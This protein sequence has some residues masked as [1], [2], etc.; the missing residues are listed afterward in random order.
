MSENHEYDLV[1]IGAGSGGVRLARM[2]AGYGARVAVIESRYLGGTCVN[3]GCVP[4]KLF[5]YG[6]HLPEEIED[7]AGYGW[8]VQEGAVSFDWSTLVRNK[9]TEISRLNGIY[10][11]LL[12]GAGVDIIEGTATIDDPH[13]VSVG[14]RRLRARHIAVATGS[15]P[16][17][18]EIPGA[19]FVKTSN[20]MFFLDRL[21]KHAI[22]WGGGYIAVEF[23]GILNGLGVKTTLV[24]RGE[25]F[26]RGFDQD[27]RTFVAEELGKK[28]IELCFGRNINSVA[29]SDEGFRVTLDNGDTLDTGL[30]L[31]ATGRKPLLDGLGLDSLGVELNED[32]SLKVD[33]QFRTSV[34]SIVALGDVIGTPQLTPVAI[35]QGMVL[36]RNLFDGGQDR[37]DYEAIPTAV[38]CQPNIGTVGLTEDEARERYGVLRIYRTSFRPMKYTLSGRDERTLMKLVVDDASDRVVGAHMVGPDAGEIIQGIAV[39]IKAG[40]TKAVFDSTIGI[41]PTSAEEFVTMRQP[42]DA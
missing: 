12:Q 9:N 38:F 34:P 29:E 15:W 11:K 2:S 22:V 26:L 40:A 37:M 1:V 7:A 36:S 19:Q 42:V 27:V 16:C 41:H 28:G 6:S 18:P 33:E 20:E 21:P 17:V 3:V 25:L 13:T 10:E 5:V 35:R 32:G 8:E 39:A 4:K 14:D 31:A 23:A 24:Y 30:V